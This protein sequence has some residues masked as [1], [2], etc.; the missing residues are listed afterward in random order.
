VDIFFR[1]PGGKEEVGSV[2]ENVSFFNKA[3]TTT[4]IVGN[5]SNLSGFEI[6]LAKEYYCITLY[7]V[8]SKTNYYLCKKFGNYWK[9]QETIKNKSCS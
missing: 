1:L 3:G 4:L 2:Y 7:E 6:S 9:Y 8:L 5:L